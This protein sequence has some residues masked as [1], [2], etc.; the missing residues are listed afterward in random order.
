MYG[1]PGIVAFFGVWAAFA[2]C[3]RLAAQQRRRSVVAEDLRAAHA[4]GLPNGPFTL[5]LR[6][7]A[8]QQAVLLLV[9]ALAMPT[10]Y[11]TMEIPKHIVNHAISSASE[12]IS[13]DDIAFSQIEFLTLLCLLYLASLLTTS[14]LKYGLNVYRGRVGEAL[15]RR[16]RL[17]VYRGWR[18]NGRPGG[19]AQL[20]PLMVQEVEPVGSFAGEAFATPLF[21]G[22]TFFTLL[23]F[24]VVQD[25]VL[26][27]AALIMLP[28]Q[29]AVIPPLQRRINELNRRRVTEVRRLGGRLGER[30][31]PPGQPLSHFARI[32]SSVRYLQKLRFDIF[33][34]KY[35]M[36][37]MINFL[38]NMVPFF[39]YLIGGY[40]VIKGQI[41]FGALVAVLAAHKDFSAPVRELLL[42]YQLVQDVRVRY[43]EIQRFV[44]G[45]AACPAE[46]P[47]P[48]PVHA[49]PLASQNGKG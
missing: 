6:R 19:E 46:L 39:F 18:R 23:V 47:Y 26:G 22:A 10:L 41:S 31:P 43:R 48:A 16:L 3:E 35:L 44:S 2:I 17:A 32:C 38:N 28:V 25:P 37:S 15:T 21:Q 27:G 30:Q 9:T 4:V 5:V 42:Y 12:I 29:L 49:L 45:T 11:L 40:L 7:T 14:A 36:K 20:I 33:T 13:I 8:R 24:M 34:K 1:T